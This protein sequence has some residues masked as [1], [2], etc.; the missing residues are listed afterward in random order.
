VGLFQLILALG[1]LSAPV[2]PDCKPL[3]SALAPKSEKSVHQEIESDLQK[4]TITRV[5]VKRLNGNTHDLWFVTVFN[6]ETQR[7]RTAI[8]KPREWGDHDGWARAPMEWVAYRLNRILGMDYIPPTVYRYGFEADGRW[9]YEAPLILFVPGAKTLFETDPAT[10]GKSKEAIQS[11]H[12]ILCVL[13]HNQDG[14]KKN[15]LLGHHWSENRSAPV[16]IDFGASLR[17]GTHVTLRHYPAFG[18]TEPVSTLSKAT[19]LALKQ[20]S[21]ESLAEFSGHLTEEEITGILK[22]RDGILSYFDHLIETQGPSRV[23]IPEP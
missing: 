13:L 12:R 16:F 14:H 20:L 15:L 1:V 22:R 6:S 7:T 18:N 3:L 21:R 5:E 10:W 23:F 8:M 17:K 4:G 9:I 11:D 19:Y 2:F